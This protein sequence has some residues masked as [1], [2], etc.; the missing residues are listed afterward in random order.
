MRSFSFAG[1]SI[2]AEVVN[3]SIRLVSVSPIRGH[4]SD[5]QSRGASQFVR[6]VGGNRWDGILV[7]VGSDGAPTASRTS[8]SD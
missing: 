1:G 5:V 8:G 6:F 2:T 7:S 4:D 3:G